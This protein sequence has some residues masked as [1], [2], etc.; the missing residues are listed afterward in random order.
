[1]TEKKLYLIDGNSAVYRSYYAI[2]HLSNTKGFPTNA[3]FGFI[4]MLRKFMQKEKPHY[5]G[6]AFDVK[7]P[8]VRHKAFKDYKAQRKPMPEDLVVQIPVIKKVIQALNIPFFEHEDYEA[9]DVLGSLAHQASKRNISSVI[10]TTDKDIFQ[11]VD[12]QISVYN[13]VKNIY[14]DE[15]KV[16]EHFGVSPSQVIDVLALWGDPSDNVP[17]VPGIGEKTS[18]SLI[19]QFGSLE[20]LLKKLDQ[21]DHDHN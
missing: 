2:R 1:M 5:L 13:P 16:K 4:S 6:I 19:N 21:I 8:T 18:K 9:D 10:V 7:G 15:I 14:L 20:N 12:K 3:I 17:G 11:L